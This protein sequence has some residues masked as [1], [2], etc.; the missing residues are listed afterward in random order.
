[1]D[2]LITQSGSRNDDLVDSTPSRRGLGIRGKILAVGAVGL[3]G[4]LLIGLWSGFAMS[5]AKDRFV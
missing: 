1:M 3:I 4:A 2:Q 5:T